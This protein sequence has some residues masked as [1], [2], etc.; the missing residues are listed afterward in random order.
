[1]YIISG[2]IKEK[3]K[4]YLFTHV[5]ALFHPLIFCFAIH[6]SDQQSASDCLIGFFI[7]DLVKKEENIASRLDV[8]LEIMVPVP[9]IFIVGLWN[10][11][12]SL[13]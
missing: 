5:I 7:A 13:L 11:T 8:M 6:L 3:K 4:I 2:V 9:Q 12:A 10:A 1:M